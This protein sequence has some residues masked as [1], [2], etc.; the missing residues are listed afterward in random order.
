VTIEICL[1]CGAEGLRHF[2]E[3]PSVPAHSCL[4]LE[5]R[6][7]AA[8]YPRGRIDLGFC[9]ACGFISNT[10]FDSSLNEYSPKYEET[11][12]YSARF[13]KFARDLA[14]SWVADYDLYDRSILEIGCGK[15][16]F[17]AMMCEEG[18]GRG[19]GIDPGTRPERIDSPAAD[20]LTW[21]QDFYSERYGFILSDAVVSRHTL[22]HI[23]PVG[24]MLSTIRR[25]IGNRMDTVVLFELPDVR[26]VLEEIAFWDIYYEH[27]S[28]FSAGSMARA[29]RT[30]GFD[31]VDLDLA[32]DDQY[33]LLAARP[34]TVANPE[35][36]SALEDDLG[37]LSDAVDHFEKGYRDTVVHWREMLR[38]NRAAGG[39]TVIWGAGSKGVS[40]L[41]A[42]G[43][44]DDIEYAVDI[45][46]HKHDMY[47]AGTGQRIVPPEFL[48]EYQ[49]DLVIAM[50]PVYLDEIGY[51]L[52]SLGVE[53][54]LVSL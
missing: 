4:L 41:S 34:T 10:A 27:C 2:H 47:M 37:V 32:F 15:G 19:I 33:L 29:F 23:A 3:E 44:G 16:E 30:A 22:E 6:D 20:R 54:K 1:A 43:N 51:K 17:L 25:S 26:R 12:A 52:R 28:Y 39:R 50:N 5:S 18:A 9:A 46:P 36:I 8:N 45:N 11:Q 38:S 7:E 21:I 40:F 24:D 14:R 49:P 35:P 53:A 42:M 31:V 48:T 13:Q